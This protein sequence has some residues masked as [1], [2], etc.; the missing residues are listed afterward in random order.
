MCGWL[1]W[2]CRHS[3]HSMLYVTV[4]C[5]SVC[6]FICPVFLSTLF[7]LLLVRASL[8]LK[9]SLNYFFYLRHFN[10]DYFILHY[11]CPIIGRKQRHAA[12]LLLSA[13]RDRDTDRHGGRRTPNSNCAAARRRST[14]LSSVCGQCHVV[15]QLDDAEHRLV[16][17]SL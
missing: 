3:M 13:M 5:P 8:R 11:V 4:E 1:Y 16:Y 17:K 10:I 2:N 6:L 15:S 9:V 7:L 12:G 14:A